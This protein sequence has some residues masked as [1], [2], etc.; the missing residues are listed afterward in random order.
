MK[1][2]VKT[3]FDQYG[4]A[5]LSYSPEKIASFY[6]APLAI[7]SDQGTQ[8]V[9]KDKAVEAFWKEGVK[10]YEKMNIAK[11]DVKIVSEDQLSEKITTAKVA[12]TN[13]NALGKV[14]ATE[15]NFYILSKDGDSYKISG[16]II[17]AQ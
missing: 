12:W 4:E 7:Y 5:L 11:T 6:K 14:V 10:P 13:T 9:E 2:T 17:M 15:T 1:S 16:L 8:L 3:F